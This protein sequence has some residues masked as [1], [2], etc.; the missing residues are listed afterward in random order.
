MVVQVASSDAYKL[1][2]DGVRAVR[3][4]HKRVRNVAELSAVTALL[5]PLAVLGTTTLIPMQPHIAAQP[6]SHSPSL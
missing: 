6:L 1:R 2:S 5:V 4:R 3:W